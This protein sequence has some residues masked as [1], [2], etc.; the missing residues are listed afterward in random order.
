MSTAFAFV[1]SNNNQSIT[2]RML[3]S[4]FEKAS[5]LLPDFEYEVMASR[6]KN[7]LQCTGCNQCFVLGRCPLDLKDDMPIIKKKLKEADIII[8]SSPVYANNISGSMKT[9]IDRLSYWTHTLELSKK[10]A[11]AIATSSLSGYIEVLSYLD[12]FLTA[13][14]CFSF[15]AKF[16]LR[17]HDPA[18][19]EDSVASEIFEVAQYSKDLTNQLLEQ[20]FMTRKKHFEHLINQEISTYETSYW[21]NQGL[22]QCD[23][24]LEYITKKGGNN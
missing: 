15:P 20:V 10:K 5:K 12:H 18:L 2:V 24:F 4:A 6:D 17:G 7:L 14:G 3:E 16:F 21:R 8:F 19:F 11:F 23:T 1:G 13:M 22:M 9:V